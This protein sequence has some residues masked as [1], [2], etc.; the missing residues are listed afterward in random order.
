MNTYGYE[1][2]QIRVPFLPI[3][4]ILEKAKNLK[5]DAVLIPQIPSNLSK[6]VG[7][8]AN[9]IITIADFQD[10]SFN[11]P[12]YTPTVLWKDEQLSNIQ[13]FLKDVNPFLKIITDTAEVEARKANNIL[14]PKTKL[15]KGLAD[16]FLPKE[17]VIS[18]HRYPNGD[19][20]NILTVF[21]KDGKVMSNILGNNTVVNSHI[22]LFNFDIESKVAKLLQMQTW[23]SYVAG[24]DVSKDASLLSILD[25]KTTDGS[26]LWTPSKYD[27]IK[28]ETTVYKEYTTYINKAFLNISKGD[29]VY[30]N[31]VDHIKDLGE[32]YYLMTFDIQKPKKGLNLRTSFVAFKLID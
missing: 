16:Q 9:S 10:L 6:I 31:I 30:L 13:L 23:S 11:T 4:N 27:M 5:T 12:G 2:F 21:N 8:S 20:A 3:K 32:K 25:R 7:V 15:P 17:C 26:S 29:K 14:D 22:S 18:G 1:P 28:D 19:V 24:I